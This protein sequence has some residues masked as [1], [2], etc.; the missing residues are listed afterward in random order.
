[1][2]ETKVCF[3]FIR[4]LSPFGEN[5]S[6]LSALFFAPLNSRPGA[7]IIHYVINMPLWA[8]ARVEVRLSS[9]RYWDQASAASIYMTCVRN[10]YILPYLVITVLRVSFLAVATDAGEQADVSAQFVVWYPFLSLFTD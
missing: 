10:A 3:P 5:R 2:M 8:R 9:E 4:L 6:F 1:M 7:I